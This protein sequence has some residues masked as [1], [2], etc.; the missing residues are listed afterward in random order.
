MP[1]S[2][3]IGNRTPYDFMHERLLAKS[4]LCFRRMHVHIDLIR[5]HLDEQMQLRAPLAVRR[6]AV[7]VEDRMRDRAVLDDATVDEDVL[8]SAR[9]PGVCKRSDE[10][11]HRDDA[12]VTP[13]V[14]QV[15]PIPVDLIKALVEV[16]H[17]RTL[18]QFPSRTG[19]RESDFGVTQRELRHH[20]R[21]LCRFGRVGFQKLSS[22]GKVV[23][24][25]GHL[26]ECAFG[27]AGFDDRL[28]RTPIDANLCTA[29]TSPQP[30]AQTKVRNRGDAWQRLAPEPE[31]S[32]RCQVVGPA[33]LAG[34]MTFETQPGIL[35]VHAGPIVLHADQFLAAV[36]DCDVHALSAGIDGVLNQ[37][38]D[39]R[40]R[41]LDDLAG[42]NLVGEI[43]SKTRDARHGGGSQGQRHSQWCRRNIK[44]SDPVSTIMSPTIHQNWACSPPGKTGSATFM[45]NIPVITV[46]GPKITAMPAST[47]ETDAN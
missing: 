1:S 4:H 13:H 3:R 30:R 44:Y 39:D 38:L 20:L 22:R 6:D 23:E 16:R 2:Q 28:G 10:A 27:P 35:R 47:F 34:G 29:G 8:R 36:L 37:F 40:G 33:N 26:D 46:S 12:R 17:R 21:H 5:R 9:R 41:P 18:Q 43:V 45:P 42:R 7:G 15:R 14:D 11:A 32:D 31:C 19:E 24:E 25:V